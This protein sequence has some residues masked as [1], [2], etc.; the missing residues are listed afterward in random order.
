MYWFL[1]VVFPKNSILRLFSKKTKIIFK[2]VISIFMSIWMQVFIKGKRT[3]VWNSCGQYYDFCWHMIV[4]ILWR[5]E[6]E[7]S[8]DG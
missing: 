4:D 3:K 6:S 1:E 2:S 7:K 8:T 5:L